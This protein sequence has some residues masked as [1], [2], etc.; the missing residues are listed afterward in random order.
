MSVQLKVSAEMCLQEKALYR[1]VLGECVALC[2]DRMAGD[3]VHDH[4][5]AQL[6]REVRLC[7]D[8][9]RLI[10]ERITEVLEQQR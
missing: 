6:A 8:I 4:V 9:K 5:D 3:L 1:Q 7:E 2:D 10:Q